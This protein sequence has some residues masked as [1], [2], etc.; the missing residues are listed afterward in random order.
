[1]LSDDSIEGITEVAF[2][3]CKR[4]KMTDREIE[5]AA[6]LAKGYTNKQIARRMTV[7]IHTVR[8]HTRNL[9][10]K[11]KLPATGKEDGN[12]RPKRLSAME[13]LRSLGL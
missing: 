1:M 10:G 11:L 7:S 3:E 13:K 5:V 2:K 4:L 9:Y 6:L 12:G 8:I